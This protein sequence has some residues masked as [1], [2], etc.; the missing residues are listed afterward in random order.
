MRAGPCTGAG[1]RLL[2]LRALPQLEAATRDEV[3]VGALLQAL[4]ERGSCRKLKLFLQWWS[5]HVGA[6]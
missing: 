4:A 5:K 1:W 6:N 2:L 3:C